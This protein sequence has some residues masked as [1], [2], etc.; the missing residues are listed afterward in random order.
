MACRRSDPARRVAG[1][2]SKVDGDLAR[3][4]PTS[5]RIGLDG[6][7]RQRCA[8]VRAELGGAAAEWRLLVADLDEPET[9]LAVAAAMHVVA[10]TAGPYAPAGLALVE[11]CVQARTDY[12]DL[13]GELLHP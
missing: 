9:L 2:H 3:A 5:V 11:A 6:R 10:T 1:R 8:A 4:A 7:S 12:C 13:G